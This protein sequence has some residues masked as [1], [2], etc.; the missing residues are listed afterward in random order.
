M[1]RFKQLFS[2]KKNKN[3]NRLRDTTLIDYMTFV[4]H[5]RVI[6]NNSLKILSTSYRQNMCIAINTS[7]EKTSEFDINRGG[8]V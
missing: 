2:E 4:D 7:D 5:S 8:D 3:A 1:N 6:R